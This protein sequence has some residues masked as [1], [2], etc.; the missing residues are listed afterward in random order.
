MLFEGCLMFVILFVLE[1]LVFFWYEDDDILFLDERD[2]KFYFFRYKCVVFIYLVFFIVCVIKINIFLVWVWL[3]GKWF[4]LLM[5]VKFV[6]EF[7]SKLVI[8]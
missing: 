5:F 3:M 4:L 2:C 7:I 8:L 6:Y 1:N